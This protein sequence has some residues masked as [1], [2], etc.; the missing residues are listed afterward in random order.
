MKL[1][2]M[3]KLLQEIAPLNYAEEWDNTGLLIHPLSPRC[4]KKMLLTIDLTEAVVDEA[5]KTNVDLII[6]YHPILFRP[7]SRLNAD[8]AHD[9]AV[10]KLVQHHIAVYSPHTA[11]DAVMGGVND[12]LAESVGSGEVHVLQPHPDGSGC[13]QGRLV[14]LD[15]PVNLATLVCRIKTHLG[16]E[17]I[18][19]AKADGDEPIKTVALCA[20]AGTDV[21]HGARAGLYLTG[22]MSHHHVLAAA[23]SGTH[24]ILCEHTNTERGYLPVLARILQNMLGANIE[25]A[26]SQEDRDPIE[27]C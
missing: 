7:L 18:R 19:L 4:I 12:W 6:S 1:Q 24:V 17:T 26:L 15:K 27:I 21:L 20:G 22:E 14:H 13:G 23:L 8:H 11:L 16:L 9:R 5:I 10:M 25:I 2:Q 3:I